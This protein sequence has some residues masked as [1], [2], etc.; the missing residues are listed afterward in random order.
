MTTV[1][2]ITCN[3][4]YQAHL[5]QGALENEGIASVLHNELTSTVMAGY[6]K[7]V[8]GVDILVYQEDIEKALALLERNQMIP[9]LMRFCPHCGSDKIE[10]KIKRK[11]CWRALVATIV[12]ALTCT[13]P[14]VD[15]WEYVCSHCGARFAQ[16]VAR[17]DVPV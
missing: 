3:D 10:L 7:E 4:A 17:K 14:K 5:I 13:A 11:H 9:E 12:S 1:K 16:P 2:L 15:H 6:G 8:S